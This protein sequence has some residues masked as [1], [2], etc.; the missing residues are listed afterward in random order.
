MRFTQLIDF[1]MFGQF[2]A[3]INLVSLTLVL[4]CEK[5]LKLKIESL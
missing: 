2:W 4:S 1:G 5:Q 3:G